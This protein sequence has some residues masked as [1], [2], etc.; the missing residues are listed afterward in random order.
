MIANGAYHMR[1]DGPIALRSRRR[2]S[3]PL[4]FLTLTLVVAALAV[5]SPACA[6]EN[7]PPHAS[8]D[9]TGDIATSDHGTFAL[10]TDL[11]SVRIQTLP[12]TGPPVVHYAVH[13]ETDAAEPVAHALLQKYVL[14]AKE[15]P[16]GVS[17]VGRL[18]QLR[19]V[20]NRNAQYWVQFQISVPANFGVEVSTG[21]GDIETSD[22]AGHVVLKTE[23]GNIRT[24]RLG[25]ALYQMVSTEHYAAKLETQGGHIT[26]L[27]VA[28]DLDAF[29]AGGHIQAGNITGSAKL[30][31]GGGHIRAGQIGGEARL[32]TEG[33]NIAVGEAG[34]FVSVRTGGGQIDFGE[35]HGS[36]RAQTAGGGIRMMYVTGPM[37]VET[38]GGSIC[39]THVANT[40][41]AATGNG[42]ITGLDRTGFTRSEASCPSARGL[43]TFFQHGRHCRLFA[44]EYHGDDRC[45][46]GQ[47]RSATP[48]SGPVSP[49]ESADAARGVV[50]RLRD[51]K[52]GRGGAEAAH[53]GRQNPAAIS[54]HGNNA[55]AIHDR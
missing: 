23:G 15:T 47:R 6:G 14:T 5:V 28:G 33:G 12:A 3:E 30:R 19:S 21:A 52:W 7:V 44:A 43:A 36:V 27:D 34:S 40:L 24:G 50:A 29:T 4:L 18:P 45:D 35:V 10:T 20:I 48:R 38:S 39:L 53:H 25:F 17:L 49:V 26:V 31:S 32:E 9:R 46:S 51:V 42:R 11:G 22:L 8:A 55:E 1:M 54:G 41:R 16:N 37:E 13:I 2:R